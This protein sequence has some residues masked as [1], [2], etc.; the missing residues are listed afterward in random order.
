MEIDKIEGVPEGW[1]VVRIGCASVGEWAIDINGKPIKMEYDLYADVFKNRVIIE[2]IA[3]YR[4]VTIDDIGK[5]VE[6]RI[7]GDWTKKRL[8]AVLAKNFDY[9]YIYQ[10]DS[11]NWGYTSLPPR[12]KE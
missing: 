2:K 8:L 7:N 10:K 4:D 1:R 6:V 9:Q 5:I 3:K 11:K 12:I